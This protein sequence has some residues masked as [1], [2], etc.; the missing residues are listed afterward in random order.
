MSTAKTVRDWTRIVTT[1]KSAT[2]GQDNH[3]QLAASLRVRS[4]WMRKYKTLR[5]I[6]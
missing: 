5:M 4:D 3:S 6:S 2:R 1:E